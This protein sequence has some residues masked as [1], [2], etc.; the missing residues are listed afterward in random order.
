MAD[1]KTCFLTRRH[2]EHVFRQEDM[3]NMFL[4]K[5]T[6]ANSRRQWHVLSLNICLCKKLL[7][8][9]QL[10]IIITNHTNNKFQDETISISDQPL[11]HLLGKGYQKWAEIIKPYVAE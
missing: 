7:V 8:S 5:K 10:H 6:C 1:M 11:L 9:L 4:G 3:K 2:E